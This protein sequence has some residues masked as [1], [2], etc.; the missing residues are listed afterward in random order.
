MPLKQAALTGDG[1][2]SSGGVSTR[3]GSMGAPRRARSDGPREVR[4]GVQGGGLQL[5][6]EGC[7]HQAERGA[8]EQSKL[9]I[10]SNKKM[11]AVS[12]LS[13]T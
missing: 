12:P 13:K 11:P 1:R 4:D 7:S 9:V 5:R 6:C 2:C 3:M 10:Q 8:A